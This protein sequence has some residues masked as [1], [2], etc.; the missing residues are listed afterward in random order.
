MLNS[1]NK[2]DRTCQQPNHLTT[3]LPNGK[4]I[5]INEPS[6]VPEFQPRQPTTSMLYV[7]ATI[8]HENNN[9]ML[10]LLKSIMRLDA[11]QRRLKVESLQSAKKKRKSPPLNNNNN[12]S[13]SDTYECEVHVFFDDAITNLDNGS[14]EPNDFVKNLI[15]LIDEAAS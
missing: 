11:D 9:E 6:T 7:C 13:E 1:L 14:S 2:M 8:W 10:Q 3:L 4:V 5:E 15:L 12:S